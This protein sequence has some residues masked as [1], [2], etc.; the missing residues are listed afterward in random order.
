MVATVFVTVPL[1][2]V[3]VVVLVLWSTPQVTTVTDCPGQAAFTTDAASTVPLKNKKAKKQPMVLNRLTKTYPTHLQTKDTVTSTLSYSKLKMFPNTKAVKAIFGF[4]FTDGVG[5]L[6]QLGLFQSKA[7][8]PHPNSA[9]CRRHIRTH[10][11][12]QSS[13]THASPRD[14]LRYEEKSALRRDY[15]KP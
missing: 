11:P 1:Q 15:P 14:G 3:T 12:C 6:C 8:A 4:Y 9:L 13:K 7:D 2:A 5:C 10:N